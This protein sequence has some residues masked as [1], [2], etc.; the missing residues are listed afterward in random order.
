MIDIIIFALVVCLVQPS[1]SDPPALMESTVPLF[2]LILQRSETFSSG[3][4]I[5]KVDSPF[6]QVFEMLQMTQHQTNV[7]QTYRGILPH[8]H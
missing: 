8:T 7:S 5:L 4:K 3:G 2:T 1:N 6:Q